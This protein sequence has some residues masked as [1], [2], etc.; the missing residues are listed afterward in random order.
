VVVGV[1]SATAGAGRATVAALLASALAATRPGLTVAVDARPG[2]GSLTDRLAP[3]LDVPAGDLLG[4]LD[5][6]ALTTGELVA[7]LGGRASCG[8]GS[9]SASPT[10]VVGGGEPCRRWSRAW[11]GTPARWCWTAVSAS[12]ARAAGPPSPP[13]T[14]SCW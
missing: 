4:L 5:Q 3:D 10:V 13:P 14:S 12:A 11:P 1:V 8:T 2:H 9:R 7:C 6:P